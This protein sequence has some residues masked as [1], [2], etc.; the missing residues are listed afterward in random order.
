MKRTAQAI[1]AV[2]A[3]AGCILTADGM[4][5]SENLAQ[6]FANPPN[7]A[8]PWV[9]WFPLDGNL[10]SNGITADLEAMKRV[11][12]G[13]VLYME[14]DQGAPAGPARFAGPLW[15]NLFKHI[16][17]EAHRLSLEVNMNNDAGWC[18]SG[19]PW[20][21]PDLSMQQLVWT[22]TNLPG[23]QNFTGLLLQPQARMSFYRDV[24]V[25]AFPTPS[26]DYLIPNFQDKS[27]QESAEIPL[28]TI[29]AALPSDATI[30]R[31]RIVNLTSRKFM[32]LTA[33]QAKYSKK[34]GKQAGA[35]QRGAANNELNHEGHE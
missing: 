7:S 11:G 15:R 30:P 4:G 31:D 18:G 1:V 5:A 12:L 6:G 26:M 25:F 27:A 23:P 14:T 21:T 13:G 10:S 24:A 32:N 2:A 19:G 28:H 29:F 20:I 34:G 17:S 33:K 22:A 35:E 16:C 3:V 9:Y 8:R